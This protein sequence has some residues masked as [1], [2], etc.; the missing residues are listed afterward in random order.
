MCAKLLKK[1]ELA[2]ISETARFSRVSERSLLDCVRILPFLMHCICQLLSCM[3]A[4]IALFV[5]YNALPLISASSMRA[6]A[7][8]ASALLCGLGKS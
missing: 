2:R 7:V 1:C 8:F 4:L 6:I 5:D 3:R